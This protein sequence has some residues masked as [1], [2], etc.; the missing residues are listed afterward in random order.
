M[1]L[2]IS[3]TCLSSMKR[4]LFVITEFTLSTCFICGWAFSSFEMNSNT[5]ALYPSLDECFPDLSSRYRAERHPNAGGTTCNVLYVS[6][7]CLPGILDLPFEMAVVIFYPTLRIDSVVI[8]R[9][10]LPEPICFARHD[11]CVSFGVSIWN[12]RFVSTWGLL[13]PN[14]T[15]KPEPFAQVTSHRRHCTTVRWPWCNCIRRVG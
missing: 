13:L 1:S 5:V 15:R 6:F 7:V 9:P 14:S 2:M 12:A 4:Y 11:S 8:R 3:F 10:C